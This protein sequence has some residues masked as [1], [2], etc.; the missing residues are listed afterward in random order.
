M[1]HRE[2]TA[3]QR[4]AGP[5]REAIYRACEVD[6]K[7]TGSYFT[8]SNILKNRPTKLKLHV[9]NEL[10]PPLLNIKWSR[11]ARRKM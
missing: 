10:K 11:E 7:M 9:N 3:S 2:C 8:V 4:V 6:H 5:Y 1:S